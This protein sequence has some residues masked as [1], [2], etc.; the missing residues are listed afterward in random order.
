MGVADRWSQTV[1]GTNKLIDGM[2]NTI[3]FLATQDEVLQQATEVIQRMAELASSALDTSKNTADRQALNAEFQALATEMTQ[4][5]DKAYNGVSLFGAAQTLRVGLGAAQTLTISQIGLANISFAAFSLGTTTDANSA[6]LDLVSSLGSLNILKGFAGNNS[7]EVNRVI[8][9]T[10]QHVRNLS[11]AE[12]FVRNID[13]AVETGNFTK[14][15]VILAA[16]QSVISQ[17]NGI[18]QSA[19]QFLG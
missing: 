3:G 15:Q 13:L 10:R 14:Q 9:F 7:N 19:L 18:I 17:S 8:D 1:R 16:S 11:Q 4:L 2:E 5:H 6:L 12:N